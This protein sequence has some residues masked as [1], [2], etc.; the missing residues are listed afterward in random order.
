M[1]EIKF[2][3]EGKE[4]SPDTIILAHSSG[5]PMNSEFM[6]YF[7]KNLSKLGFFCV[8]FQFPYM[9]K[10]II[11]G[12]KSFPDKFDVLKK[13]W[14]IAINHVN[15]KDVIIGGKSM[16]GRIATL[17]ANEVKPKGVIVLGYPFFNSRGTNENR[18]KHLENINTPTLI[19]Q[20]EN[21]NLGKRC[22]VEKLHLSKKINI[23]WIESAN[24]SLIPP[25]RT[26]KT[27]NQC[28][29]R[30]IVSIKYFINS[31]N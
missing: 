6:N 25:K 21:D 10:Q 18:L 9:T 8:R 1:K 31:L 4:S 24:H 14:L 26:G 23:H 28:W 3:T 22:E 29:D 17:I 7:S 2:I 20:G 30:C 19:C 11:E 16:G 15:K 12:K 5:A 13:S 27:M